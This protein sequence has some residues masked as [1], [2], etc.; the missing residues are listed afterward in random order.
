MA[1]QLSK[2]KGDKVA[3]KL[4]HVRKQKNSGITDNLCFCVFFTF[5]TG[6]S[7]RLIQS[8]V[9]GKRDGVT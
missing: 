7:M 3:W 2:G 1:K 6:F 9:R 8:L 4:T 5:Y